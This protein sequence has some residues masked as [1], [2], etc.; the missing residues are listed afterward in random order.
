MHVIFLVVLRWSILQS[1]GRRVLPG[2]CEHL[3]AGRAVTTVVLAGGHF[4]RTVSV[5][6]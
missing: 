6:N 2:S 5:P 1:R 4:V 3:K